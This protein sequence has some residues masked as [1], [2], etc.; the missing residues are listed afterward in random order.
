MVTGA[1]RGTLNYGYWEK[2]A[3]LLSGLAKRILLVR[4]SH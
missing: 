2:A 4:E 3:A 1:L